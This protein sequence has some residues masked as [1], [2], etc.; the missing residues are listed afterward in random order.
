MNN[1]WIRTDP[2]LEGEANTISGAARGALFDY[3]SW[4]SIGLRASTTAGGGGGDDRGCASF[5]FSDPCVKARSKNVKR[6]L[7]IQATRYR[8]AASS[9]S[10]VNTDLCNPAHG[11]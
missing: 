10:S 9:A 3:R 8:R 11:R 1:P 5:R 6:Y 7:S 2:S 4:R